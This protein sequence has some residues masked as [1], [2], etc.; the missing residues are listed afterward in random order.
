MATLGDSGS[1]VSVLRSMMAP[2]NQEGCHARDGVA[3]PV[4]G[5][6]HRLL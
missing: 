2:L 6:D 5:R 1:H 4:G 3:V